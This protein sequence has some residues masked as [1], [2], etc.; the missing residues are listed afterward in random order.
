MTVQVVIDQKFV[1]LFKSEAIDKV[2]GILS[3]AKTFFSHSQSLTTKLEL[4]V[5]PVIEIPEE[6]YPISYAA[7]R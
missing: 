4:N 7:I 5:L 3:H 1:R 6:I 2:T